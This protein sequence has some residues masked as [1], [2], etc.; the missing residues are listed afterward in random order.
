MNTYSAMGQNRGVNESD[1]WKSIEISLAIN[2]SDFH[3][4][5][6]ISRI[7]ALLYKLLITHDFYFVH[8]VFPRII[9]LLQIQNVI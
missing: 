4:R 8:R 1:M 9:S 5:D 2:W 6:V 3:V 7:G